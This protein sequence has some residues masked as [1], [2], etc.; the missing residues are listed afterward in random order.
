MK[1]LLIVTCI[2][3]SSLYLSVNC[4]LIESEKIREAINKHSNCH[5]QCS[6]WFESQSDQYH[7][8]MRG[9]LG[10]PTKEEVIAESIEDRYARESAAAQE[11]RKLQSYEQC[12][13]ECEIHL[14]DWEHP[15]EYDNCM[16]Q[17]KRTH[18]KNK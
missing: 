1:R 16:L 8:C 4:G 17:C 6:K 2:A 5:A 13:Q 11:A 14:S 18:K 10:E 3:C 7:Q 12:A 9:C 15:E